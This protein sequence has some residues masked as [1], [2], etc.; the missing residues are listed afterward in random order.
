MASALDGG[1][2]CSSCRRSIFHSVTTQIPEGPTRTGC[3]TWNLTVSY[4][5]SSIVGAHPRTTRGIHE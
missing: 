2:T 1:A 5:K 4:R 3:S